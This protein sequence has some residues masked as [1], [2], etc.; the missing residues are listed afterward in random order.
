MAKCNS[1]VDKALNCFPIQ[2]ICSFA[3]PRVTALNL[4]VVNYSYTNFILPTWVSYSVAYA[5]Y[6]IWVLQE[7]Q[8]KV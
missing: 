8:L 5:K 7:A 6:C 1:I 4:T 3:I 2:I